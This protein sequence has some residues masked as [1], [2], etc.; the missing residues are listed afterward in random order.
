MSD[1]RAISTPEDVD[2]IREAVEA[3]FDGW[4][5]VGRIDWDDFLDR[6]E[7]RGFSLPDGPEAMMSPAVRRVKAI[8]AQCR[9][10]SRG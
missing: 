9:R 1:D 4:Y 2:A 8:V 6:L 3:V 7:S 10:E 5:S